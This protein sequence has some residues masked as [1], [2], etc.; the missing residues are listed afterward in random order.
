MD[1]YWPVPAH[2]HIPIVLWA[3]ANTNDPIPM[4]LPIQCGTCGAYMGM[5]AELARKVQT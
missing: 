4:D 5:S 2:E 1:F 3:A